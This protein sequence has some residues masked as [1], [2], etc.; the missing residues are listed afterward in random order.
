MYS[1]INNIDVT[2]KF[3]YSIIILLVLLVTTRIGH[4]GLITGTGVFGFVC[5]IL[6]V[7][8]LNER[9]EVNG[10]KFTGAMNSILESNIMGPHK[11]HYLFYNSELV[12]FLDSHRE[13]Y[14]YNPILWREIVRYINNFL[15]ISH[16]IETGTQYY[17]MDYDQLKELKK[18][19]MNAYH[20]FIYTIPHT[21]NSNN[22]Y[23]IGMARLEVLLNGVI[24]Q[25]H[26]LVTSKNAKGITTS[27]A[28]HYKNHPQG[29]D[30]SAGSP[31]DFY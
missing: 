9:R 26:Q 19:I 25:I 16:D 14:Q 31:A 12:I 2:E 17:N 1:Y 11:N 30:S 5:G 24:D 21:E 3:M 29:Y 8:Y 22:K 20:S 6:V 27:S 10:D 28:F 23:H 4:H 7:Y 15:R 18:K 13:Y